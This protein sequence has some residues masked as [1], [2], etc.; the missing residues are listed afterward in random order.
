MML[1][2]ALLLCAAALAVAQYAPQFVHI[3]FTDNTDRMAVSWLTEELTPTS[4]VRFGKHSSRLDKLSQ[5]TPRTYSP[6]AGYMHD[7]VLKGLEVDTTYFYS[8][9]TV[10]SWSSIYNFTTGKNKDE[11]HPTHLKAKV[12]LY[13]DMGITYSGYTIERLNALVPE[14]DFIYHV[15]DISYADDRSSDLY[16]QVWNQWFGAMR[17]I[18]PSTPYMV[19]PGNH[20]HSSGNP[21]LEDSE[22][23]NAYNYRFRMPS[24]ESGAP[25]GSNMWFSFDYNGV[26]WVSMSTETDYTGCEF[27]STFGDQVD[28]LAADLAKAAKNRRNVPWIIVTGHK[29]MYS[30][31]N[32]SYVKE[33]MP[34]LLQAVEEMFHKYGVDMFICGHVHA[35]ERTWPVYQNQRVGTDYNNPKGIVHITV[36]NAGNTEQTDNAWNVPLTPWSA[37]VWHAGYGFGVLDITRTTITWT[38]YR[39][40]DNGVEDQF[41]IVK[42][43]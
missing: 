9:G 39:A 34:P 4:N 38:M 13:G 24:V 43:H 26:H 7:A 22:N 6:N 33:F 15:G 1:R 8:V 21:V 35:Y 28:W 10:G 29:P 12:A 14:L 19:A 18:M 27:N 16:E 3:A 2:V 42:T 40:F 36:G 30:N 31:N 37:H 32:D 23:F 5:G 25:K 41:T 17:Y 20:E 11:K